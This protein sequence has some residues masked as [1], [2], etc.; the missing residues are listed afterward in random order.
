MKFRVVTPA[1]AQLLVSGDRPAY[2]SGGLLLAHEPSPPVIA[3]AIASQMAPFVGCLPAATE[4]FTAL[5]ERVS[6]EAGLR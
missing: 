2:P 6:A 4:R 1:A 3:Q 5:A